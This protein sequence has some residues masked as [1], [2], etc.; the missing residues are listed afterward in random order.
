MLFG[1]RDYGGAERTNGTN[2]IPHT[3]VDY[4][5]DDRVT[6]AAAVSGSRIM[7]NPNLAMDSDDI[8]T[9]EYL[10]GAIDGLHA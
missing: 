4:R 10:S 6:T 7:L 5:Y 8:L 1:V 9:V 2:P 3:S